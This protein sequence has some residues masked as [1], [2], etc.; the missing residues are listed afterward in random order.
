M[1]L[2]HG[3]TSIVRPTLR[4]EYRRCGHEKSL[5]SRWERLDPDLIGYPPGRRSVLKHVV[6]LEKRLPNS[7]EVYDL[8]LYERLPALPTL[9]TLGRGHR[10]VFNGRPLDGTLT[11]RAAN[12]YGFQLHD[13]CTTTT[14]DDWYRFCTDHADVV[15]E[16][17]WAN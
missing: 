2:R 15:L 16:A 7:Q 17:G 14:I 11:A 6:V 1:Q 8:A 10:P 13:R 4:T 9:A 12:G 5:Y 3:I